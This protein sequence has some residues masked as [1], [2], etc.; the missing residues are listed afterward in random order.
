MHRTQE[1]FSPF[2]TLCLSGNNTLN[3]VFT[4][5]MR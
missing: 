2:F 3:F 1:R 4:E 5:T